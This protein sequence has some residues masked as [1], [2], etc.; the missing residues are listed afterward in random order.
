M[1]KRLTTPWT[2]RALLMAALAVVF[3]RPLSAQMLAATVESMIGQVSILK[4]PNSLS[5]ATALFVGT[6][7]K[8]QQMVVTGPDSYAKFLLGD[9]SYFEVFENSKVVFHQDYGWTHLLNVI[10]G[11]IK[12][13]IDHSKGANPNSV[14]TPTAVISVRGTIF[15]IVVEDDDGT[16]L[17]TLDEGWVHVRNSTAAGPERDL[18]EPGDF[19]RVFRGQLLMGRQA[20]P[21]GIFQKIM[22]AAEDSV[23]VLAQ[24]NRIGI[25]AGGGAG[26]VPTAG[27][28]G[29]Q[30]DK[31]KGGAAPPPPAPAPPSTTGH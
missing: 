22:R 30:G 25:P 24:Q 1:L 2:V 13:F 10:I 23:R 11:H 14:T 5:S 19:V 7:V 28:P 8:A 9:G 17:V 21:N 15:D 3:L 31:G 20:D 18:R 12:V 26:G 4:D 29:A 27:I 16:T 6:Q